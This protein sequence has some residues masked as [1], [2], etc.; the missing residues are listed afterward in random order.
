MHAVLKQSARGRDH[1]GAS[2]LV[3]PIDMGQEARVLFYLEHTIQD[4]SIDATGKRHVVSRQLQFLEIDAQ[5]SISSAGYAPFL[6]YRPLQEDESALIP[7]LLTAPWLTGKLEE[8]GRTYAIEQLVPRHLSE[9]RMRREEQ[10]NKTYRAVNDRLT[11]EISYWDNR[12]VHLKEQ[13]RLGRR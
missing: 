7:H 4:A 1:G 12:A 3:D 5:G 10:I 9:V 8:Q 11:K 2:I 13:H 6:N